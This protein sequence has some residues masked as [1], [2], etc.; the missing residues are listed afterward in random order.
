MN[1][2]TG[3]VYTWKSLT[4]LSGFF[5]LVV[6]LRGGIS[7]PPAPAMAKTSV[8]TE[9]LVEKQWNLALPS[10]LRFLTYFT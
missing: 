5:A 7:L 1:F 2:A 9:S 8:S 10:L 6:I 4:T 3:I